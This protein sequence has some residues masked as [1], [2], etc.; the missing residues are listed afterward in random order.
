M[1]ARSNFKQRSLKLALVSVFALMCIGS[2][3]NTYADTVSANGTATVVADMGITKSAD[4]RF[5]KFS[6]GT[7]GT[8]V[9]GTA[10]ART[11]TG[12]VMLS[13]LDGGVA[14]FAVTGDTTATYAITLPTT[15]TIT[16]TNTTTTMSVGTFVSNPSG[17]GAMTSG[18]Q[19]L[20]VGGTLTVASAQLT[21]VYSGSFSVTVDYN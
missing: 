9:M 1:N 3:I 15:A 18:A 20:L 17:T 12:A 6:A 8:V 10:S 4:L 21:G 13:G 19:T 11:K 14:S 7:G 5:G 16:H 2:N